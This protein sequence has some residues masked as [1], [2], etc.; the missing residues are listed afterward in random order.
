[1]NNLKTKIVHYLMD[2]SEAFTVIGRVP[3][4]L[5]P[6]PGRAIIKK[7]EAYFSQIYFPAEGEDDFEVLESVKER[8]RT[9]KERYVGFKTPQSIPMLPLELTTDNFDT[10]MEGQEKAGLVPIGLDEET[11][12]PFKLISRKI[13]IAYLSVKPDVGKRIC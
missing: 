6:F 8:V 13:G 3:F 10:Y 5:E 7:E 9:L 4:D 11:V 2:S 12:Q 1:M